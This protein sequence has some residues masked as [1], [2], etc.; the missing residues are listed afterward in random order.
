M[1]SDKSRV[2][3]ARLHPNN[4]IEAEALAIV[5]AKIAK[6]FNKREIITDALLRLGDNTPEMFRKTNTQLTVG[7]LEGILADF[8]KHIINELRAV[9]MVTSV[10]NTHSADESHEDEDEET[11]RNLAA[12]FMNRRNR[13]S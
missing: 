12:G 2:I 7:S 1:P 3:A 9:G 11:M 4:K 13:N 5:D 8:G 6:G 10:N